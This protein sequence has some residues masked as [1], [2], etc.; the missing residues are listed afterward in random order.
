M[1]SIMKEMNNYQGK[2]QTA[3]QKMGK[4][5]WWLYLLVELL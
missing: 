1:L 2:M 3:D 5:G 4:L